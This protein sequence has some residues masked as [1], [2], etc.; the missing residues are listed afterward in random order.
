M[1]TRPRVQGPRALQL[2][3]QR[4]GASK[5]CREAAAAASRRRTRGV[6]ERRRQ[7]S[8]RHGA[9]RAAG[10]R[11][12]PLF[13]SNVLQPL[14]STR[15]P[16]I[17]VSRVAP[18][19]SITFPQQLEEELALADTADKP[20]ILLMGPRRSGKTS[21][22]RV[23]FHK[24]SP[25]ETLF[26]ES[27]HGCVC[28]TW[29]WELRRGFSAA[30]LTIHAHTQPKQAG[31]QVHP[32]Q[33]LRAVSDLGLPGGLP[34]SRSVALALIGS[35]GWS[36][37]PSLSDADWPFLSPLTTT[38]HHT[39]DL[40]LHGEP[41]SEQ[42]A[43]GQCSAL[44]Y[45]LDAQDEPYQVSINHRRAVRLGVSGPLRSHTPAHPT[46]RQDALS[47]LVEVVTRAHAVNPGIC[48]EVFIHKVDGDLFLSDEHKVD[49]HRDIQQARIGLLAGVGRDV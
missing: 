41:L 25:H 49:C 35:A 34:L 37:P 44:V 33:P 17:R 32:Q 8:R 4:V 36:S 9:L 6:R 46:D 11:G 48:F 43:F 38:T 3:E 26:L 39:G 27:T 24:M 30:R 45:V 1:H 20:R 42:A 47:R 28:V 19:R 29:L 40:Y 14:V 23:V 21:I 10:P 13:L 16:P 31:H 18:S 12:E 2:Q 5:G 15:R 7:P 22:E